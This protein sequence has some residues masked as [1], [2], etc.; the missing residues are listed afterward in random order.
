MVPVLMIVS[1]KERFLQSAEEICLGYPQT[2]RLLRSLDQD[3]TANLVQIISSDVFGNLY[4]SSQFLSILQDR[5]LD[6]WDSP[7]SIHTP[8]WYR[9]ENTIYIL[10]PCLN[11]GLIPYKDGTCM[12]YD[13]FA[14]CLRLVHSL[15]SLYPIE[16]IVAPA[17]CCE[18]GDLDPEIS[19]LQMFQAWRE[20]LM[21]KA[22]DDI[23]DETYSRS[24]D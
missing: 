7:L 10:S 14:S 5:I 17:L 12:P 11:L 18:P 20:Y 2:V 24:A 4:G 6:N 23:P 21:S 1:N 22:R 3:P 9:I 8:T 15:S 16:K 13:A 19:A